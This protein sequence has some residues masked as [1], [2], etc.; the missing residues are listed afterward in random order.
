MKKFFTAVLVVIIILAGAE[1]GAAYYVGGMAAQNFE[2]LV[3][4]ANEGLGIQVKTISYQRGWLRS[5][6]VTET[7]FAGDTAPVMV[8]NHE[9]LHGPIVFI[10]DTPLKPLRFKL[11]VVN[12]GMTFPKLAL[13]SDV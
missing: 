13:P 6:A 2:H 11:A 5:N 7:T 4:I 1:L 9:I 8:V 12:S 10:S 3:A